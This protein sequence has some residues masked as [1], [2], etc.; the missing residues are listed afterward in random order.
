MKLIFS[1]AITL[2]SA[3]PLKVTLGEDTQVLDEVF[4][5]CWRGYA[6]SYAWY[7]IYIFRQ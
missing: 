5:R 3:Q 4:I 2:T 1:Q 7:Q 6:C